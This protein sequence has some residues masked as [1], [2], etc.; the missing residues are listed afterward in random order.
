MSDLLGAKSGK[1]FSEK[2]DGSVFDVASSC[3]RGKPKQA[4]ACTYNFD[5]SL[6]VLPGDAQG[7]FSATVRYTILPL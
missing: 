2:P 1:A 3:S 4:G 7:T 5:Y 6:R